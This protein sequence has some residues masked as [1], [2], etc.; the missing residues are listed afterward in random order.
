MPD[1]SSDS[2]L[3][4]LLAAWQIKVG[5]TLAVTV[6]FC[7]PYI[8]LAHHAFFPV[9]TLPLTS[10]D[11][12]AGFDL[13]WVWV[14]QSVYFFTGALP[15][16]CRTREQLR[17]YLHGFLVLVVPCFLI[18]LLFPVAAPRPVV[19]EAPW[20]YRL[21]LSYD[22]PYNA[23]PS[24]HAG[25]MYLNIALVFRV[26]E[27]VRPWAAAGMIGWALLILWSTL[28]TKQHYALD[29]LA[30]IV[31]AMLADWVAWR[32]SRSSQSSS[33]HAGLQ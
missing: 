28:A 8:F 25:F 29:L 10:L 11:R 4:R 22:G 19:S 12:W 3:G 2:L 15:W 17:T 32:K 16:L 26:V 23:M 7:V 5:L 20:M 1:A 24:L 33:D 27:R 30:G 14:Y 6:L 13:R 21:L 9:R 31:L 18:Y